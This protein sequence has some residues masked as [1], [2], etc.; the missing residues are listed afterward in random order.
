M[1]HLTTMEGGHQQ[2]Q[3]G[4]ARWD[5]QSEGLVLAN[6]TTA[7]SEALTELKQARYRSRREELQKEASFRSRKARSCGGTTRP[8]DVGEPQ[9]LSSTTRVGCVR[10]VL[11][12][13]K[14]PSHSS[15][16]LGQR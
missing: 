16:R 7:S 3:R 9:R 10:V 6:R 4:G 5:R 15:R 12:F 11:S 14:A 13:W 2:W 8:S 1:R